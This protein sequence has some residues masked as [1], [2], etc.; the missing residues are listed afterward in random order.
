MSKKKLEIWFNK[1]GDMLTRASYWC[2][3]GNNQGYVSEE[4]EDFSDTLV[5]SHLNERD[6][7]KIY[8]QSKRTGRYYCMF[9]TDFHTLLSLKLFNNNEIT[10]DFRFTKRGQSQGIRKI[11]TAH[12]THLLE[13][14]AKTERNDDRRRWV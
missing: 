9:G 14:I 10:G 3:A 4:G 2:R 7:A 6:T 5:Y 12:E 11:L 1:N 8:F 13:E